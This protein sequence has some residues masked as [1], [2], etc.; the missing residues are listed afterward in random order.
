VNAE[1]QAR[2]KRVGLWAM[3]SAK[4]PWEYRRERLTARK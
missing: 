4:P 3:Q 2:A 1:K